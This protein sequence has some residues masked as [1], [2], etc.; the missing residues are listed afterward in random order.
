[1]YLAVV[2][3][4]RALPALCVERRVIDGDLLPVMRGNVRVALRA[5]RHIHL[6]L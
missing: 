2:D 5:K 4:L 1:M 6:L 3:G